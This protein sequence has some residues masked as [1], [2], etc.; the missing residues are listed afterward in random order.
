[1]KEKRINEFKGVI[2]IAAGLIILAALLSFD[3]N[4]LWWY[5]SHPNIPAHNLIKSFGAVLAGILMF[6]SAIPVL[7]SPYLYYGSV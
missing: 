4:D 5:S 7:Q 1:V 3:V 2:L 6:F